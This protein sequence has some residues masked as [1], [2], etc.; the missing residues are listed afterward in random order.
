MINIFLFNITL[1]GAYQIV[2]ALATIVGVRLP[3]E[4]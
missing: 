1:A 2:L 3:I 4:T